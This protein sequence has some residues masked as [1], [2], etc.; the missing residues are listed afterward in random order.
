MDEVQERKWGRWLLIFFICTAL[1]H[2]DSCQNA[3]ENLSHYKTQAQ[4]MNELERNQRYYQ[5]T[6]HYPGQ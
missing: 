5:Q 3:L 1:L 2:T 6:G 4:R